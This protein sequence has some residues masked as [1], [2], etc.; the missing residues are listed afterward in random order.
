MEIGPAR[1]V[2]VQGRVVGWLKD[3]DTFYTKKS[4]RN[5]YHNKGDAI[6]ITKEVIE[7][8]KN[9]NYKKLVVN[10]KEQDN[11]YVDLIITVD[12]FYRKGEHYILE[13]EERIGCPRRRFIIRDKLQKKLA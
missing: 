9:N 8:L 5:L 13:G 2:L 11:T 3:N 10:L 12:D 4:H 1:Q 6:T 7:W